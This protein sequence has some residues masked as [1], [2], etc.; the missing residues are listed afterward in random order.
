[1]NLIMKEKEFIGKQITKLQNQMKDL[2]NKCYQKKNWSKQKLMSIL[3]EKEDE[4][5]NTQK[6]AA[7]EKV[8]LGEISRIKESVKV[9]PKLEKLKQ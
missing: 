2:S 7:E 4:F 8:M 9:M 3:A 5:Q 1:M 6:T